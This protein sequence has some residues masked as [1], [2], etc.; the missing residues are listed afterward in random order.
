MNIPKRLK[1]LSCNRD[2][3]VVI[4]MVHAGTESRGTGGV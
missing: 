4:C 3:H 1:S 2:I